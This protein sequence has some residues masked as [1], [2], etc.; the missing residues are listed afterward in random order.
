MNGELYFGA[1]DGEHG[2][3]IW[4]TNGTTSGTSMVTDLNPGLASSTYLNGNEFTVHT[5]VYGA[6]GLYFV[7]DAGSFG[8][9]LYFTDG[10]AAGT[11]LVKDFSYGS[12]SGVGPDCESVDGYC[13]SL[14]MLSFGKY[15]I[16]S[17]T[18]GYSG[19]ELYYN[20]VV[21]TSVFYS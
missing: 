13:G 17:A 6:E 11:V 5:D 12:S 14:T 19:T 2:Y 15:L 3:E 21:E 18:D 16:F 10:T 4:K 8:S 1:D 9:E 7:G 20:N